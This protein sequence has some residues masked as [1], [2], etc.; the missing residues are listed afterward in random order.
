M[1]PMLSRRLAVRLAAAVTVGLTTAAVLAAPA[2]AAPKPPPPPSS[3]GWGSNTNPRT[4]SS[5]VGKAAPDECWIRPTDPNDASQYG[6]YATPSATD[7]NGRVTCPD[8]SVP[9]VN[10]AYVWGLTRTGSNLWFGT[11]ANTQCLVM[12]SYLGLTTPMLNKTSVCEFGYS[13]MP[14]PAAL[15]DWRPPRLFRYTMGSGQQP[16]NLLTLNA[17]QAATIQ[18]FLN[19]T[20]GIRSATS[21][22]DPFDPSST[23]RQLIIFAGPSF[24]GGLTMLAFADDGTYIA[25]KNVTGY[26]DIRRWVST[27]GSIYTGVGKTSG[28]GA[29]LKWNP[30]A[31]V[32]GVSAADY[33]TFTELTELGSDVAEL[34]L[35]GDR[36][37]AGTWPSSTS[38]ATVWI[39]PQETPIADLNSSIEWT[40]VWE[41]TDY[42]PD[43]PTAYTYGAGAMAF[44]GG[45]IY[46]GTMHVPG[47]SF[48]AA[49][50]AHPST[51][52]Q[53]ALAN[54]AGSYR[55]ISIF[56]Y[57]IATG[58]TQLLYGDAQ[59]PKY[60]S[61]SWQL[62][63]NN[64]GGAAGLYGPSGFGNG[65]NNYTWSMAV[66]GN[67]LYVGTMDWSYLASQAWPQI[68]A[69]FGLDP[70][71]PNPLDEVANYGADLYRFASTTKAASVVFNNGVGN[72]LNYG[73][74]NMLPVEDASS[75]INGLYLGMADP[76]N[77]ATTGTGPKGGWELQRLTLA[78]K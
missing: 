77:L 10:Q 29:V 20:V 8:G 21:V 12:G 44:F 14:V 72:L 17:S 57:N 18:G 64:M 2:G 38:Q 16:V 5:V 32:E 78:R 26:N 1:E 3:G 66:Y 27:G 69:Q 7:A 41:A 24:S 35:A 49:E 76:E 53:E 19:H 70:S 39:S 33:L 67:Q 65:F 61:G 40:K 43:V 71:T 63:N 52:P 55:A 9:K 37:V 34:T 60:D 50:Q 62:V 47:V 48:E 46:W 68:A 31:P 56:R 6:K 73:I 4:V 75:S 51:T 22:V 74:R 23:P 30:V 13:P 28:K 54:F 58:Q 25:A 59:L 11:V 42:D 45:Y 15:G 36:L